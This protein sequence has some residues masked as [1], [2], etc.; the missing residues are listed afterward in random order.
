M[1]LQEA[2]NRFTYGLYVVG[3]KTDDGF[4]G[5]VVDAVMQTTVSPAAFVMSCLKTNATP[6]ALMK[7]P[8]FTLSVLPENVDPYVIA[9]FGFQSS[10]NVDK[11]DNVDHKLVDGLPV[12]KDCA[13]YVRGTV[14]EARDV[15]SHVLFFCAVNDTGVGAGEP[16]TYSDYQKHMKEKTA[17]AF[18]KGPSAPS[19]APLTG[20][21]TMNEKKEEKWVCTVCGYVYDGDIPFEELPDDYVCP[22]CG[23]PKSA[24][25]KE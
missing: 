10:R 23:E 13:A 20:E 7:N 19:P 8:Q 3:A 25:E 21:T 17:E 16:L 4:A 18:K 15:G 1:S 14:T 12:L 6:Q 9:N 2:L 22:I 5:C 11:W 24:F